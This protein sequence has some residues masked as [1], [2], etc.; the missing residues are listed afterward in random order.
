MQIFIATDVRITICSEKIY[1]FGKYS[2]ILRRYYNAFGS[3]VLCA[4]FENVEEIA[5]GYD[6]ISDIVVS[7][8]KIPSLYNMLLNKCKKEMMDA[9]RNCDLVVCRCPSIPAYKAADCAKEAGK[10]Y[11]TECMG[12]PW[13]A[14]WNHGITGKLI[15]PYMF[16]KMKSV[17]KKADYALY[18]T[19]EF[20]QHRYPTNGS[21][22]AASNVLVEDTDSAILEK[23]LEKIKSMK[24]TEMVL[25]TTAA[26][27]VRHKGQ[28]YVIKAIPGL[29]K[30]GIRVKYYLVGEGDQDYLRRVA[31]KYNVTDQVIFL[32]RRPLSKVFEL[33]DETDIYVQ[34]SLQEGLPRSVI[35]AMSRGCIAV[36]A[37]TAGIPELL[38][39]QYVVKRK[40][41]KELESV[42]IDICRSSEETKIANAKRNF[43]EAKGYDTK[44]LDKK[45]N[46]YY[47]KIKAQLDNE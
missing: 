8:I 42:L 32:G 7:V 13:D 45:R 31:E 29:N 9:I 33:L 27:N 20:L 3:I 21:S 2:T 44:V 36:G 30:A 26:V 47:E 17:V 34:P 25:M 41:V 37:R 23:R 11:F 14:Y 38:E 22:I 15:A 10:P 46:A 35:E 5:S 28:Q 40:G 43:A 39:P 19:N 18:V 12:D 4:R 6:D 1:A 24:S 16:F